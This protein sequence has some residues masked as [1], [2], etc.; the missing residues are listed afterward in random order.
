MLF[1][2]TEWGSNKV[3]L[4]KKDSFNISF[5]RQPPERKL[6]SVGFFFLL[7][8]TSTDYIKITS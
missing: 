8:I 2:F 1:Q 5:S 6:F 3:H 7:E 4:Q